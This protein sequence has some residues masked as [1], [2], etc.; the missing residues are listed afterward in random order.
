MMSTV[1]LIHARM[2]VS[3]L[4]L[5]KAIV[6]NVV[7]ILR[8]VTAQKVDTSGHMMCHV[9]FPLLGTAVTLTGDESYVSVIVNS[10]LLVVGDEGS[11]V[12]RTTDVNGIIFSATWSLYDFLIIDLFNGTLFLK[13]SFSGG[14]GNDIAYNVL[15]FPL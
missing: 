12:V 5:G 4:Q 9:M 2:K 10:Q 1:Y 14:E 7:L 11:L 13:A 8:V 15:M 6:V 3:V